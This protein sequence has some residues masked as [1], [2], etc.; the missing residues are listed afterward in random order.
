MYMVPDTFPARRHLHCKAINL[1]AMTS[2][3]PS[4]IQVLSESYGELVSYLT[5]R[6]GGRSEAEDA[7]QDTFLKAQGIVSTPEIANPRA[8]VFRIAENVAMDRLRRR[9][10]QR[11]YLSTDDIPEAP[12]DIATAE[13][14]VDYRQRLK[15]LEVIIDGLP[16]RQRQVFLMHKFD[17]MSHAE[18]AREL[19][20][21]R[22]GVEKLIMKALSTC[23]QKMDD[24]ID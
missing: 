16:A 1:S 13:Q 2:K 8:Y 18:I 17:G 15:R 5:L 12:A 9:V 6:L 24:L 3:P 7:F 19:G 11:R 14:I 22:S 20:I 23:R 4:L 10:A 21:S